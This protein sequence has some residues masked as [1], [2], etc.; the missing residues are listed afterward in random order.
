MIPVHE[1]P[2]FDEHEEVA[3]F[4]DP[5]AGLHAIVAIHRTSKLGTS[6]GGVRL[7]PYRSR[8]EALTD[9]LRLSRAMS[10]KLALL[11]MPAGGAKMVVIG[12]PARD[13]TEA[14]LRALARVVDSFQGRLV[15]AEDVGT[16]P[17]DMEI[18]ARET[19]Y[20]L[21]RKGDA[22]ASTAFGVYLGMREA[23]RHRLGA[24]E[25][26]GLRVAVQGVGRVG[27]ALARLLA[28]AS[29]T[30]V[31]SDLRSELAEEVAR[32]LGAE[33]VAPD[34]V[35]EEEVDVLAPCA[36][37]GIL[38]DATIPR[39]RC[40][41]VA[42]S[43]NEQLAERR[44][45]EALADRGILFAPDL[46]LST[47]AILHTLEEALHLDA[48][49]PD[50]EG[51]FAR[52][53]ALLRSIFEAAEADGVTPYEVAISRAKRALESRPARATAPP[54]QRPVRAP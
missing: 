48:S 39:L 27:R 13:K 16:T 45:A 24:K 49:S 14:L 7:W 1:H 32:E 52:I 17:E 28:Q 30:L 22:A 12:D 10:Y 34:A 26:A 51:A 31:V 6:G 8:D 54:D 23:V 38:N 33:V 18:I 15:V 47:G 19:P 41:V 9:A 36:M 50:A 37:G 5:D 4:D 42:G 21:G 35:L 44:H 25:L 46:V 40:T 3:F 43:A 29:A 20:V 11:E 2:D 53:P